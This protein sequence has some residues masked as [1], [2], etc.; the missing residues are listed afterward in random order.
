MQLGP[1][2]LHFSRRAGHA[3]AVDFARNGAALMSTKEYTAIR[4][5]RHGHVAEVVLARPEKL[6]AMSRAFFFEIERAFQELDSDRDVRAVVLWAEGKHFTAGLD[7]KEAMGGVLGG[8][9]GNGGGGGSAATRNL[10][11]YREIRRLQDCFTAI[12]RCRKPV[13]AA[14]HSK[15]IGGGLDLITACDVRVCSAD[16]SF[17]IYETKIAIVADVGTLQRISAVAGKGMAREMA[18]T[19]KFIP[20]ERALACGLVNTVYPDKDALLAGAR[21]L[22]EEIAANSP[23][24]VQGSKVVLNYSDEHT[25]EEGLEYVAQWNSSFLMTN[26]LAEAMQAFIEKRR[27]DFKGE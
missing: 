23:L 10:T 4:V 18:Y 27:P 17:A 2:L 9:G 14:V 22:A 19:G 11:L 26:D 25:V 7:L 6:N 20:A 24:A 3:G 12:E 1:L 13:I 8:G 5:E 16:A 21:E 15:C